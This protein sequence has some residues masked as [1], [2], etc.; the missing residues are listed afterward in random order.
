MHKI[1][2][3]YVV[4]LAAG[5]WL[6]EGRSRKGRR[7]LAKVITQV[8]EENLTTEVSADDVHAMCNKL[9][10]L[11]TAMSNSRHCPTP[12]C[13]MSHIGIIRGEYGDAA[14]IAVEVTEGGTV[15]IVTA[16]VVDREAVSPLGGLTAPLGRWLLA[17][18]TSAC[19]L[20]VVEARCG[21]KSTTLTIADRLGAEVV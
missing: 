10:G 21:G 3:E 1:E 15:C 13:V 11:L 8:C 5:R 4:G 7:S 18:I 2:M 14:D 17:Y 12:A 19:E 9:H 16:R 6:I 20:L